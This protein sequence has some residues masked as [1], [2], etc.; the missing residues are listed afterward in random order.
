VVTGYT[1]PESL[2]TFKEIVEEYLRQLKLEAAKCSNNTVATQL[3]ELHRTA[4]K[5]VEYY[6]GKE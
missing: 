2:Q 6:I 1:F 4:S 3:E 5:H